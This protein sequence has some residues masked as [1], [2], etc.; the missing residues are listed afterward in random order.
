MVGGGVRKIVVLCTVRE[1]LI[2]ILLKEQRERY[3]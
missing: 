1:H 2:D 3:K